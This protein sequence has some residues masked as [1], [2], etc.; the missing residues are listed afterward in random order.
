VSLS[1]HV[2]DA[3]RGRPAVGMAVRWESLGEEAGWG[4]TAAGATDLDGRVTG[5]AWRFEDAL[6][7][8]AAPALPT[9]RH[10]L[11]FDVEAWSLREGLELFFPEVTI[12]FL[13]PASGAG[14]R[15]HVPLLLSPYAYST[16][17]GS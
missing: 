14:G 3:A 17:R 16:Y 2:L 8:S 5:D 10:R 1:T 15:Y 7:R 12:S 4:V 11:V 6:A 9:G 13:V